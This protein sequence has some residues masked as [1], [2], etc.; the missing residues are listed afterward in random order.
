MIYRLR[1]AAQADAEAIARVHIASW[2]TTYAG[3]VPDDVIA[4]RTAW[5]VRYPLW[6]ERLGADKAVFVVEDDDGAFG[7]AC[8]SAMP[9]RP[10]DYEPLPQFDAYLEALYLLAGRQRAGCGRALLAAVA[11]DLIARGHRSLGLHVH[12][13][14]PARGFYERL[15]AVFVRDEPAYGEAYFSCAYGFP[16]LRTLLAR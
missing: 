4:R 3:L 2:K 11:R 7:F 1:R 12:A 15:G 5:S 16:D 13:A 6:V 8:A 10:Q 9:E 14:N